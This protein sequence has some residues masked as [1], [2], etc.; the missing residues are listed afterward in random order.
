MKLNNK[1][2]MFA[3]LSTLALAGCSSDEEKDG[4]LTDGSLNGA[5]GIGDAS[6]CL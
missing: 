3:L 2:A 5:N 1:M 4:S 6:T